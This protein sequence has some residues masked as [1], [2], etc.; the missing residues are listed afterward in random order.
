MRRNR[1]QLLSWFKIMSVL[2]ILLAASAAVAGEATPQLE[3]AAGEESR[4]V[5]LELQKTLSALF[6]TQAANGAYRF[7]GGD[8]LLLEYPLAATLSL[9]IH[10]TLGDLSF[11]SSAI[12][13]VSRYIHYVL[14]NED[15]DE[16][17]LAERSAASSGPGGRS[18][19]EDPGYNALL[20]LECMSLSQLC[21]A[22]KKPIDALFWREEAQLIAARIVEATYDPEARYFFPYDNAAQ[23]RLR[24]VHAASL[25]PLLFDRRAGDNTAE[26]AIRR[27]VLGPEYF[28]PETPRSFLAW[29]DSAARNPEAIDA[30]R[31]FKTAALLCVL[32]HNGYAE[33]GE[34]YRAQA[35]LAL[36]SL[37][38][39]TGARS[40]RPYAAALGHFLI[41]GRYRTLF[42]LYN[43]MDIL[44]ELVLEKRP[45]DDPEIVK[46]IESTAAVKRV[47]CGEA[48]SGDAGVLEEGSLEAHMRGLYIAVSRLREQLKVITIISPWKESAY[49]GAEF[50]RAVGRLLDDV[51]ADLRR[52]ENILFAADESASGLRVSCELRDDRLV[53]EQKPQLAVCVTAGD[54]PVR[55]RSISAD[56]PPQRIVL[57]EGPGGTMAAPG[58]STLQFTFDA[59][60]RLPKQTGIYPFSVSVSIERDDGTTYRRNF[61]KGVYVE[62]PIAFAV[63]FPRGRILRNFDLPIAIAMKKNTPRSVS[64]QASF[65]SPSG[66]S[67]K[68]GC[69]AAISMDA[70]QDSAYLSLHVVSPQPCRP[71]SFPFVIKLFCDDDEMGLV[72]GSFFK[73]YQWLFAGPFERGP[74]GDRERYEPEKRINLFAT[75]RSGGRT[76]SWKDL[77]E[78]AYAPNGEILL[79]A[80]MPDGGVGFLLTVIQSAVPQ[81]CSLFLASNASAVVF[82]NGA[83]AVQVPAGDSSPPKRATLQLREGLNEILIK[84][85][86][87]APP[88][89][90]FKLGD[91][92]YLASDEFNNNLWELV[93]GYRTFI[94]RTEDAVEEPGEVRKLITLSYVDRDAHSVS[95]I[96]SFNGWSPDHATMRR[97]SKNRW[98]VT[99]NLEP[100]KYTYRFLINN[101]QHVLTKNLMD[102]EGKILYSLSND[103]SASVECF[104]ACVHY[105]G[106]PHRQ[107]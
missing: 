22:V 26:H 107:S 41:T 1:S 59:P 104:F 17:C 18:S 94:T 42:P 8:S 44:R 66:L 81:N 33:I 53:P 28:Y 32:H 14:M 105:A 83:A 23:E 89:L 76:F 91:D 73:H 93:E 49:F 78:S 21:T 72:S 106:Q 2:I 11:T 5:C 101:R 47:L 103:R 71:G 30:D 56:I 54:R 84:T 68:E 12:A 27:Y 62:K 86:S 46:L 80:L 38:D 50:P 29:A 79:D 82:L 13:S 90:H 57:F 65:Y 39:S 36:D 55:L 63:D 51:V 34:R 75:F 20:S 74:A 3:Q 45:L 4:A 16:D 64:A 40:S 95:I 85:V 25:L 69:G 87:T 100:G 24:Y 31:L 67:L 9:E 97:V 92:E 48:A 77:P 70:A 7:D 19:I 102:T 52:A 58:D 98:E 43:S 35:A 6:R 60:V 99:V 61:V 96:G 10:N 15:A 37:R 88:K